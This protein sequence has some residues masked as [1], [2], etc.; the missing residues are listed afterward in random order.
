MAPGSEMVSRFLVTTYFDTPDG[1]L[2]RAGTIL[3]VRKEEGRFIQTLKTEQPDGPDLLARGEWE[4]VVSENRPDLQAPQTG[5]LLQGGTAVE[6]RPLFVTEVDRTTID[7]EPKPGTRVEAAIDRGSIRALDSGRTQP[8]SEVELE[9]KSGDP[10]ALYDLALELLETA[11]LRIDPCS[12]SARGYRLVE[13]G[14]PAPSAVSAEPIVLDPTL[15]IEEALQQVGR[16]C[17]AHL[18]RNEPAALARDIEGVH[19]IRVAMRRLRSVLA[20]VKKMLPEA[21]RPLGPR[22]RSGC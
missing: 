19:Q 7:I 8:L 22:T 2:Q 20:A 10:T 15:T 13:G 14:D 11:P 9:L 4:D 6:L 16:A 12:K 5:L 21:E 1:A 3:R 18:L 17:L